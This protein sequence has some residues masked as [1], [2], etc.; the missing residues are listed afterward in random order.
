LPKT[1]FAYDDLT[2]S[3]DTLRASAKGAS[4]QTPIRSMP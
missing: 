1:W 4:I 2:S 3:A